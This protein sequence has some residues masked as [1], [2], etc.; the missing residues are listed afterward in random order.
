M[1]FR[2][3]FFILQELVPPSMFDK[4]GE[5]CWS[6]FDPNLLI[7]LDKLR[8]HFG[9][10]V[11]NNWH[12]GGPYKESGLRELGSATG[13]PKSAHKHGMAADC[14]PRDCS[15]LHMYD[16]ILDNQKEFPEVKR[17]ENHDATPT[18][19]HVDTVA[20]TGQGIRVFRP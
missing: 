7:A 15:V 17:M 5:E 11:I 20:H 4:Y 9:P 2:P 3:K 1:I 14:K 13:A 19:V 18:W 6:Y 8:A 16:Y 12:N 10:I